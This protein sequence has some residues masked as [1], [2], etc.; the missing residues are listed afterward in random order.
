MSKRDLI[1]Q[2]ERRTA[3]LQRQVEILKVETEKLETGV[4]DALEAL[5]ASMELKLIRVP[6]EE[7][8]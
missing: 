2:L 7:N 1:D 6:E 4:W 5:F 8:E 3:H